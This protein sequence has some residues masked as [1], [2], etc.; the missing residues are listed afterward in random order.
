MTRLLMCLLVLAIASSA[1]AGSN[2]GVRIYIDFDPPN[3]VH[4]LYPA[5]YTT[6]SAYVCL[7]NVSTGVTGVCFRME[8]PTAACPGV[9]ATS[10]WVPYWPHPISYPDPW[11]PPEGA[12][13]SS[14]ECIE[15]DEVVIVGRILVFYLGGSC[16]L[17]LLDYLEYP[18][19]V[20]DCADPV[21]IDQY[22]VL[23]HGSI[24]GAE[25][26]DGDCIPVPVEQSTWGAMKS[27][28]R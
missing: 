2:P 16:C 5:Q 14:T 3:Y 21:G 28:Y 11:E 22:C 24:G 7:D 13:V 12:F 4:E 27:L 1:L 6:V 26:P 23:A 25:C 18:R 20:L 17:E 15:A 10:A 19:W 8:D 9:C